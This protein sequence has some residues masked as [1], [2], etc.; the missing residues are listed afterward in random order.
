MRSFWSDRSIIFI[1]GG[2]GHFYSISEAV[3]WSWGEGAAL[4]WFMVNYRVFIS[5]LEIIK[6]KQKFMHC[7][8]NYKY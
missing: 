3:A 5:V 7:Q 8:E 2:G 4:R 6:I 1:V